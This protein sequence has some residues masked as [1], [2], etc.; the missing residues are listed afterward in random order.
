LLEQSEVKT[1]HH[2][3]E[4]DAFRFRR[5]LSIYSD[6]GLRRL[7]PSGL[8]GSMYKSAEE[9][10]RRVVGT[11]REFLDDSRTVL[12]RGYDHC[13]IC[14]RGLTDELSRSRGIGPECIQK[15]DIVAVLIGPSAAGFA[16]PEA[17]EA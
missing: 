17:V 15:A 14:G 9:D 5:K 11:I 2:G 1:R 3:E 6:G 8:V 16:V 12:A 10:A 7:E 13:C 4:T